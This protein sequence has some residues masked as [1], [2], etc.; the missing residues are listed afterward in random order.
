MAQA[1][2]PWAE[3][4]LCPDETKML[5]EVVSGRS[6]RSGWFGKC[7]LTGLSRTDGRGLEGDRESREEAVVGIPA[8]DDGLQRHGAAR[9]EMRWV[10]ANWEGEGGCGVGGLCEQMRGG[11]DGWW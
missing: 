11:A 7:S 2:G 6:V 5:S 9:R 4:G 1:C 3:S 10:W 8:R